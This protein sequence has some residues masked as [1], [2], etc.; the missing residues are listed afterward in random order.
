MSNNRLARM[1]RSLRKQR[2]WSQSHLAKAAGVSTRTIQRLERRGTCSQETL[3]SVAAA[4]DVDVKEFT[5]LK[6]ESRVSQEQSDS[7]SE[8]WL[9][10]DKHRLQNVMTAVGAFLL[11]LPVSFLSVGIFKYTMQIEWY[12]DPFKWLQGSDMLF[13][14]WNTIS[15]ALLLGCLALAFALNLVP[16]LD[17]NFRFS[18]KTLF[19]SIQ[20]V[21][22]RWNM[23]IVAISLLV[24]GGITT[25]VITENIAEH[26][27]QLY[28]R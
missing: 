19:S 18:T 8:D 4:F 13:A 22:N 27:I 14:L 24:I 1:V 11:I 5:D 2:S 6:T 23:T 15:P 17:L 16:F 9:N 21:G 25:Y 26:A 7:S 3:L 28:F 20:Y 10:V 12:P